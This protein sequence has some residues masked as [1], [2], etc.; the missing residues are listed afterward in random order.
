MSFN[1]VKVFSPK[2]FIA[3]SPKFKP[4]FIAFIE[5]PTNILPATQFTKLLSFGFIVDHIETAKIPKTTPP[6]GTSYIQVA[7]GVY[8]SESQTDKTRYIKINKG[9]TLEVHSVNLSN[10]KSVNIYVPVE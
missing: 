5:R 1:L 6:N 9:T 3:N 2:I 7:K 4:E 10:G 8:A